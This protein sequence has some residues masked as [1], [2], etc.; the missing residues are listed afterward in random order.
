M[1]YTIYSMADNDRSTRSKV[2]SFTTR[3]AARARLEWL[4]S[5]T[6]GHHKI[7]TRT[8]DRTID[9]YPG[10]TTVTLEIVEE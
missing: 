10:G 2:E 7:T 8:P 5:V 4:A 9:S 1:K 3:T 6:A